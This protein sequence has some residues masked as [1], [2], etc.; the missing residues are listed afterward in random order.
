LLLVACGEETTVEPPPPPEKELLT[1]VLGEPTPG[2]ETEFLGATLSANA[3][4]VSSLENQVIVGTTVG[5]YAGLFVAGSEGATGA[6]DTLALGPA[7]ARVNA[8]ASFQSGLLVF[9]PGRVGFTNGAPVE[10][11]ADAELL[12]ELGVSAVTTRRLESEGESHMLLANSAAY[13]FDGAELTSWTVP[14]ETGAPTAAAAREDLLL[15]AYEDR[16]YELDR[17]SKTGV[18]VDLEVGRINAIACESSSCD[19]SSTLFL[20]TE[21]GLCVRHSAES[22][23]LYPLTNSEEEGTAIRGFALDAVSQRLYAWSDQALLQL[24]S[25]ALPRRVAELEPASLPRVGAVDAAGDLWLASGTTLSRYETGV[26]L[27]FATDVLPI[28]STFCASCHKAGIKGAPP[29]DLEDYGVAKSKSDR[30]VA[31]MSDGSMPP[32]G[33]APVPADKFKVVQLWAA[34]PSP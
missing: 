4:A 30:I 23:T 18:A 29:I 6:I 11:L 7:E 2:G 28:M 20:A 9:M 25:D 19:A 32:A 17:E 10:E 14:G 3:T 15:I 27:S 24:T 21:R 34:E 31:R 12:V 26:P 16:L 8:L 22:Y 33:S 13:E 1:V 5:A